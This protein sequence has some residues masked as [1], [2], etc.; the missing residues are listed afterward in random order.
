MDYDGL[1]DCVELFRTRGTRTQLLR[2]NSHD[3]SLM[4]HLSGAMRVNTQPSLIPSA[5]PLRIN[6]ISAMVGGGGESR[7][8]PLGSCPALAKKQT[9]ICAIT[10]KFKHFA[11]HWEYCDKMLSFY[12]CVE[13]SPGPF[14]RMHFL[15]NFR[16]SYICR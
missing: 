13:A 16:F 5:K 12:A 11:I 9:N 7:T 1:S 4:N 14:F 2:I 6:P 8:T 10:T 3:A 15:A